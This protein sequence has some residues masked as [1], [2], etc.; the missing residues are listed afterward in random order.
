V[1]SRHYLPYQALFWTDSRARNF[2]AIEH[3]CTDTVR[4]LCLCVPVGQE[5]FFAQ[6]G[7]P[8][9]TRTTTPPRL[10]KADQAAAMKKAEELAPKYRTEPS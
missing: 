7:V 3:G 8:L 5:E 1:P 6:V 4:L 10:D 9:A 2:Y